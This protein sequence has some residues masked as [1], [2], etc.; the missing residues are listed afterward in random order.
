MKS[1][2]FK[3][4]IFY[5]KV[6]IIKCDSWKEIYD[7]IG[8]EVDERHAEFC[9]KKTEHDYYICLKTN[10]LSQIAHEI[11]HLVNFIYIDSN[12]RKSRTNDEPEAYL[13]AYLFKKVV[14]FLKDEKKNQIH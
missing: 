9:Y 1:K 12:I 7:I 3:L 2:T 13:F 14:K 4:P 10:N 11:V 5:G 8:I 6:T